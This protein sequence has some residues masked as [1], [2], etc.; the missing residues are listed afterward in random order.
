MRRQAARPIGNDHKIES[1]IQVRQRQDG[2]IAYLIQPPTNIL[3]QG[4][5]NSKKPLDHSRKEVVI[6]PIHVIAPAKRPISSCP[7]LAK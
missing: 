4:R 1:L 7:E 2:G 3:S 5:I 6:R